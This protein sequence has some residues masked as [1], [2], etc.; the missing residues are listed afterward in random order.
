MKSPKQQHLRHTGVYL[1]PSNKS[2]LFLYLLL[3][4]KML[5]F[6]CLICCWGRRI[7]I[8]QPSVAFHI[9]TSYQFCRAKQITVFYLKRNFWPKWVKRCFSTAER[10]S[11]LEMIMMM[12]MIMNC[13]RRM[14]VKGFWNLISS[15][16]HCRS[17]TSSHTFDSPRAGLGP[18]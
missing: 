6:C 4:W 5:L 12:M 8:D 1:L 2:N 18:T 3:T 7:I 16:C 9:E 14:F 10:S 13:F 15:R 17:L 11:R